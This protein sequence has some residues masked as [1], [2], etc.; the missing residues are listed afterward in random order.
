MSSTN[1]ATGV[2]GS[3]VLPQPGYAVPT[4]SSRDELTPDFSQAVQF[5][6]VLDSDA[7]KFSFQTFAEGADKENR[8]LTRQINDGFDEAQ[9]QLAS[10]N[11]SGAGIF[12]TYNQTNGKGRK[13]ADIERVRA[14]A[15]DFDHP[16]TAVELLDK[17]AVL[18]PPSIVIESS[19]GL[20]H[21]YWLVRDMPVEIG[22]D[23]LKHLIKL[24]GSDPACSDISRVMR[25]PGFYHRKREP[26]MTRIFSIANEGKPTPYTV[27]ELEM[28]FGCPAKDAPKATKPKASRAQPDTSSTA[29]IIEGG[30]NSTLASLAGTMRQRGISEA[31]IYAALLAE[32]IARCDPPL[33]DAEVQTIAASVASYPPSNE[34]D[35]LTGETPEQV[36]SRLAE[37]GAIQYDQARIAA[38]KSLRVRPGTLDKMVRAERGDD[39]GK[40]AAAPFSE[41]DAWPDPVAPAEMLAEIVAAIRRHIICDAETATAAALWVVMTYFVNQFDVAPLAV[42]TAPEPRCGKSEF[43]RLLGKMVFRPVHADGMSASVLFRCFNLW[44]PTLLIDEY[45]T[46]IKDDEDLRGILNSG[47]QR[48]GTIWR[49]VGDDHTPT[50]FNVFG[51]KLL[52]GIGKL[53]PTITDRSILLELRRKLPAETVMRQRDVVK[54]FFEV[55]QQ[56]LVRLAEDYSDAVRAARPVM[57]DVLHDRQQDNWEPLFQIAEVAGD[58][59]PERAKQAAL[60][61]S[62]AKD[63]AQS[64]GIELLADIHEIFQIFEEPRINISSAQLIELLCGDDEMSWLT[65]NRGNQ[66]TP[67][68][69]AR[70]LKGFGIVSGSVRFGSKT[71]KGFQKA[72]FN[73]VFARYL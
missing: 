10:L 30:R 28:A 35:S 20:R 33:D 69:L 18:L 53:P 11:N 44:A 73:D 22:G 41:V 14:V 48:G 2:A 70:L 56:K 4:R 55:M 3:R 23:W 32:N 29:S 64:R 17:V 1:L 62:C 5:L 7:E 54:G 59:W 19:P 13:K 16:E 34:G 21:A 26:F 61:L 57:P 40:V 66:I 42:I 36:I 63:D 25:L 58:E 8:R 37:L 15:L 68:Q 65:Y 50:Q 38:A 71:S 24:A 39:T 67:R 12:V 46:F 9:S 52:A 43:R 60:K 49:C 6:G 72:Q 31:A 45:D 27:A 47:H 51:P